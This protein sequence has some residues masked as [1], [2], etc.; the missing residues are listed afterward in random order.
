M[1][2]MRSTI[3]PKS[4]Q[5]N[6]DD[7][8]AGP[9]TFKI[10]DVKVKSGQEQPVDISLDGTEKFYRPCK[11]MARVLVHAWGADSSKYIG[12]S[13]TLYGDPSVKWGGMAVGGIRISHMSDIDSAITMALTVTRANK[14]PYT[15]KPITKSEA[16]RKAQ[17]PDTE[18]GKP[19]NNAASATVGNERPSEFTPKDTR[20]APASDLI[21]DDEVIALE[22]RCTENGVN[23][24]RLKKAAKVDKIAD[25][26][27]ARL[28]AV[29][30]W[31]NNT[32]AKQAV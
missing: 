19:L 2:D 8:V 7:F 30:E 1:S 20:P 26:T 12:R 14:K 24:D 23:P 9:L 15:V 25:I 3:V 17:M 5:W 13:L 32:I 29:H 22:A 4:D 28:P 18:T 21:T 27:A 31:L 11:S 6:F 16:A 10:R